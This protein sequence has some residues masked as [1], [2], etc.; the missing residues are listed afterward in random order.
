MT[1]TA[2]MPALRFFSSILL[3]PAE[4]STLVGIMIPIHDARGQ[5][6]SDS[7]LAQIAFRFRTMASSFLPMEYDP[8]SPLPA[9]DW[10]ALSK[11]QRR[12]LIAVY[13]RRE[14]PRTSHI[15]KYAAVLEAIETQFAIGISD[16]REALL[17]QKFEGSSRSGGL[18][19]VAWLFLEHID[20]TRPDES[21]RE[22]YRRY[23]AF[24]IGTRRC[25]GTDN[26]NL[27]RC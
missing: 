10:L 14:K 4:S 17:W 24:L 7:S 9:Q 13:L 12:D 26:F 20:V 3:T 16:V 19:C 15:R 11:K 6:S 22:I 1:A 2:V 23:S 5:L 8:E 27:D 21:P 25:K 18:A